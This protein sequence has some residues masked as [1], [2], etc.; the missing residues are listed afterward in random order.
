MEIGNDNGIYGLGVWLI[1][2][3]SQTPRPYRKVSFVL[4]YKT[5]RVLGQGSNSRPELATL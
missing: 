1:V 5:N 2:V 4:L 3:I